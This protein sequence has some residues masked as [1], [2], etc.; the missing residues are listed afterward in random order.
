[1][2]TLEGVILDDSHISGAN[3]NQLREH[4]EA[5]AKAYQERVGITTPVEREDIGKA[6]AANVNNYVT[7]IEAAE[8]NE[9]QILF[10]R[11]TEDELKIVSSWSIGEFDK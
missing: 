11:L 5:L 6:Y 1:M 8:S 3:D 2:G 9:G 4:Y 10:E 7:V